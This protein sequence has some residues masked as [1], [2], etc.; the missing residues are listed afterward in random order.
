MKAK[1]SN[2]STT[3][4]LWLSTVSRSL[5][6]QQV[7]HATAPMVSHRMVSSSVVCA[8]IG[9]QSRLTSVTVLH[10]HFND[11]L[12]CNRIKRWLQDY[13]S[14]AYLKAILCHNIQFET[15]LIELNLNH[16]SKRQ[17]WQS[18]SIR[19][20]SICRTVTDFSPISSIKELIIKIGSKD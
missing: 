9:S 19:V 16:W 8:R 17:S 10:F 20:L 2:S 14:I 5:I 18:L 12:V 4:R 7:S 3:R 15:Y 13:Y 11:P 1:S 6:N